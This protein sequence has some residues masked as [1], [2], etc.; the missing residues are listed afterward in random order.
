[1]R[2]S[3][4]PCTYHLRPKTYMYLVLLGSSCQRHK[5]TAAASSS[6]TPSVYLASV[7]PSSSVSGL[8]SLQ[9]CLWPMF[10]PAVYLASVPSSSVSGLCSLQWPPAVSLASA[11]SS[12]VSGLCSLQWPLAVS[13]ASD[14][15]ITAAV[16]SS[17]TGGSRGHR[18]QGSAN[19]GY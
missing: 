5:E 15:S 14:P 4:L 19:R 10:P 9:Q 13:L 1:M 3:P 18:C 11:P 7:V 8:C 6:N 16:T 17:S 2:I 12:S